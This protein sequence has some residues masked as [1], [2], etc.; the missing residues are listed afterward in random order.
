MQAAKGLS[1]YVNALVW[2]TEYNYFLFLK[3]VKQEYRIMNRE[4][5]SQLS[6]FLNVQETEN[7]GAREFI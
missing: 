5:F 6:L 1:L 4:Y 7:V 3:K 2:I